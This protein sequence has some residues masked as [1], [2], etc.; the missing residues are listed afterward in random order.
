MRVA[1]DQ[2]TFHIQFS[3][4]SDDRGP[5]LPPPSVHLERTHIVTPSITH[6]QKE[7]KIQEVSYTRKGLTTLTTCL[8]NT[9]MEWWG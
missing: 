4:L 1:N 3:G 6:T 5:P 2:H 8:G 9:T 7:K